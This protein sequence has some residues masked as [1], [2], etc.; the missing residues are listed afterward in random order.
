MMTKLSKSLNSFDSL[1][2]WR[3]EKAPKERKELLCGG[4]YKKGVFCCSM[5]TCTA[6]TDLSL[7]LFKAPADP[8]WRSARGS[9]RWGSSW[10]SSP[11]RH[12]KR[13]LGLSP[14]SSDR[15]PGYLGQTADACRE[16][17]VKHHRREPSSV[18]PPLLSVNQFWVPVR[19]SRG[20]L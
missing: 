15:C 18:E 3:R 4:E 16:G 19:S 9:R 6:C 8:P 17:R 20:S 14:G 13:T 12:Q 7:T 10:R 2:A 1:V 11:G 5:V